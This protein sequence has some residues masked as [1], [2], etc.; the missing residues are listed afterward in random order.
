MR[1]ANLE[2]ANIMLE[3][4][5]KVNVVQARVETENL[6]MRRGRIGSIVYIQDTVYHHDEN[7]FIMDANTNERGF[8]RM[9]VHSRFRN[10]TKYQLFIAFKANV[11]DIEQINSVDDV[12]F[13]Y[14]CTFKTG[15]R[16]LGCC[17]QV[18]SVIWYLGYARHEQYI[19][20]PSNTLLIHVED[21][22]HREGQVN[23]V[24]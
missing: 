3:K 16:T 8:L 17:A 13:G 1:D 18:A 10:A 9:R 7:E 24:F 2:L 12:I 21:A 4:A 15:A 20:Y 19:R 23:Q 11:E 14:Y 22:E 5:N 6:N